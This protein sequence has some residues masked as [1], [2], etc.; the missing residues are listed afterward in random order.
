MAAGS[1]AAAL[2]LCR[3]VLAPVMAVEG[4]S[5]GRLFLITGPSG[6]GKGTLVAALLQRLLGDGLTPERQK[7]VKFV[8]TE[9]YY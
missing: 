3:A 5:A 9:K 7:E 8:I 6:V 4:S 1:A 2:L